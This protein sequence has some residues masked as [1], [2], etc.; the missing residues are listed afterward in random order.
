MSA[1]GGKLIFAGQNHT[2]FYVVEIAN[3]AIT[4]AYTV[5]MPLLF[6]PL[7]DKPFSSEDVFNAWTD[8]NGNQHFLAVQRS[9][10]PIDI[11]LNDDHTATA[12]L[13]NIQSYTN[14]GTSN[15]T[16]AF[17]FNGKNYIM[18]STQPNWN[19]GFVIAELGTNANGTL[20]G[21]VNVVAQHVNDIPQAMTSSSKCN[22]LNWEP[23]DSKS[24]YIYQ[25]F[26]GNYMARYIFGL[27]TDETTLADIVNDGTEDESY[28]VADDILGVYIAVNDPKCVY[29]KDLGKHRNPSVKKASEIDFVA[30]QV[31]DNKVKLQSD[32][33]DQSN[34]V[35][36]QFESV[37]DALKFA[38]KKGEPGSRPIACKV[39]KGGTLTG[40]LTSKLNPT[41]TVTAYEEPTETQE[42]QD[43]V[44]NN[45]LPCNFMTPNVQS[46]IF[47]HGVTGDYFF[48]EPK[49]QEY[50]KVWWA[51]Y[52]GNNHFSVRTSSQFKGSFNVDWSLYPGDY[53]KDF[54]KDTGYSF[55]AIVRY[56]TPSEQ[57]QPLY[58]KA[59]YSD[60]VKEGNYMVF[61]LEG[62][63]DVVTGIENV[64]ADLGNVLSVTY[65]NM[66][67]IESPT[68]F[69][70]INIVVTKYENGTR[71]TKSMK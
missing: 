8:A 58:P 52:D 13:I 14:Y 55:H 41:M 71:I 49:A 11:I 54:V 70:G 19:D 7:A 37:E 63:A 45:Y 3:A 6:G 38:G 12:K 68:P 48:I 20:D 60:M 42:T 31:D 69:S 51:T 56:V 46:N 34:W 9:E 65:V 35:L 18:F 4:D 16:N 66:L 29:A 62:G 50:V 26:P 36:L 64:H 43:Y 61:P 25:Y 28:T 33:W 24:I 2:F 59:D 32:E 44:E 17:S 22:W 5:E 47:Y 39:I 1:E 23:R 53:T 10:N 30:N 21:T 67:G 27:K 40:T 15:G 57:V